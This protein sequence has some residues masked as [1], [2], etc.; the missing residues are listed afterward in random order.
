MPDEY[1]STAGATTTGYVAGGP[2]GAA[3]GF[4]SG[5]TSAVFGSKSATEMKRAAR[6]YW[7]GAHE[8][9]KAAKYQAG[10]MR[11]AANIM[12][13]TSEVA[14][15]NLQT[16]QAAA[17]AQAAGIAAGGTSSRDFALV[18]ILGLAPFLIMKSKGK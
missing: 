15:R 7:W 3:L 18:V 12:A 9:V 10:G 2:V 8:S 5:I 13:S 4:M 14:L 6:Y 16:Q 17:M 1:T 11:S